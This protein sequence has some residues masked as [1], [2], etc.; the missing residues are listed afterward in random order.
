MYNA[1]PSI[2]K[3]LSFHFISSQETALILSRHLDEGKRQENCCEG[4]AVTN[5][6]NFYIG[7][8]ITPGGALYSLA[9][10]GA[11]Y[12]KLVL[13]NIFILSWSEK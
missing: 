13:L 6:K 12:S 8:E 10:G 9:L 4:L 2:Y 7:T 11:L 5:N 1:I 3:P